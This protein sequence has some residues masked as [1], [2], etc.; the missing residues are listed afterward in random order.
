MTLLKVSAL[1]EGGTLVSGYRTANKVQ[2]QD[3]E[4][5]E[6]FFL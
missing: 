4:E 6:V 1:W 2:I 3:Q 5:K